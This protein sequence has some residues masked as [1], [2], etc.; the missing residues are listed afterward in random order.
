MNKLVAVTFLFMGIISK[1]FSQKSLSDYSYVIVSE[2]FEFQQE[3]DKYQLNSLTKFLFNKYG[4][5][6]YFDREVPLNVF[7]CDGLWAEAEGTPGFIITKVQLVLRDCTGEVIYRTNY[8]KSKVKDYKKAYY[9]S[10]RNAF[11]DIIALNV[12]QKEI[13]GMDVT[14]TLDPLVIL[15]N[16]KN[17]PVI[18]TVIATTNSINNESLKKVEPT[19]EK[20]INLNL[21]LNKYTN[22]N[23]MGTVFLLRKTAV[24]YT[25][26]QELIDTDDDLLL[27]G[28]ITVKGSDINFKNEK[29]KI[30]EVF[31]DE[32]NNLIIGSGNKRKAYN[33]IN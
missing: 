31:F 8:G 16:T 27:I 10:V 12:M 25:L 13:E 15:E 19:I 2:Q 30:L 29:D 22:Y 20:T 7:R 23:H 33:Y 6:A 14:T 9:E 32:S 21:P 3:K 18:K 5:H 11:D 4:F 24:G 28:K 26:Y 1:S 17:S